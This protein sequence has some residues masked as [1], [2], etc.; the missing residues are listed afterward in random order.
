MHA[1]VRKGL[2]LSAV[3]GALVWGGASAAS[4]TSATA[5]GSSTNNAGLVNGNVVPVAA[6]VPIQICGDAAALAGAITKAE[7]NLCEIDG[8]D[9]HSTGSANN[10]AGLIAGNVVPIAA[11]VPV[12]V[13]GDSVGA[14]AAVTKAQ[15]NT[16]IDEPHSTWASARGEAANSVGLVNGNVVP[17]S[18]NVPVQVCGDSLGLLSFGTESNDNSCVNGTPSWT[19][20]PP[21]MGPPPVMCPPPVCHDHDHDC[22]HDC[23]T[24]QPCEPH[25]W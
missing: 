19:P 20:P 3:T 25:G 14:L 11:N 17:V 18:A 8:A 15:G 2:L 16:C 6:D 4:A 7:G 1:F 10:T 12:Q 5:D 21:P 9:A 23:D 24:P 13:C 22:D